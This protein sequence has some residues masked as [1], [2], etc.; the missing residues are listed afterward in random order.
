MLSLQ[1]IE[2]LASPYKYKL[3]ASIIFD[4]ELVYKINTEDILGLSI[5]HNYDNNLFPILRFQ[6]N[7]SNSTYYKILEYKDDTLFSIRLTNF[8][9]YANK[10]VDDSQKTVENE[11]FKGYFK[12]IL[13]DITPYKNSDFN[14]E[15]LEDSSGKG[16]TELNTET[17]RMLPM[18]F[19]LFRINNLKVNNKLFNFIIED[20]N[21]TSVLGYL[22][23][24]AEIDNLIIS[25]PEN[26]K[27]YNQIIV[28]PLN[29]K[30][31]INFLQDNYGI[32]KT[33]TKVYMDFNK[34][35]IINKNLEWAPRAENE[36]KKIILTIKKYT[37]VESANMDTFYYDGE[38]NLQY[39]FTPDRTEVTNSKDMYKKLIADDIVI[40]DQNKISNS[41]IVSYDKDSQTFS[42]EDFK[43]EINLIENK[44]D[45]TKKVVYVNTNDNAFNQEELK[46]EI[47]NKET[48][49]TLPLSNINI[50]D[51]NINRI[52]T[53]N[54]KD[55]EMAQKY[56]GDY[57]L[58]KLAYVV[59]SEGGVYFGLQA[60]CLFKKLKDN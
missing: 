43:T 34:N 4:K 20:N 26:E 2:E 55:M 29:F 51:F 59:Q 53:L 54:F 56:S 41:E 25:R 44:N 7:L 24:E 8:I 30:Q 47:E 39:I 18:T 16:S 38:T 31:T 13:N 10:D 6:I 12:P 32:Y 5:E 60:M 48:E 57:Y 50:T 42:F 17:Y 27:Y 9:Y 33:G 52:F 46:Y 49:I 58:D 35:Y 22:I 3:E 40:L 37:D 28:P 14:K 36:P 45:D 1:E 19:Y 23:N 11:V 15:D 21:I